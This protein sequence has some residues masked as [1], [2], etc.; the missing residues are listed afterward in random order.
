MF[1]VLDRIE[2][3][4]FGDEASVSPGGWSCNS[5]TATASDD[6]FGDRGS[7]AGGGS[8]CDPGETLEHCAL[9]DRK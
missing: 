6:V 9:K 5:C 1:E 2:E 4:I 3:R 7:T 8:A